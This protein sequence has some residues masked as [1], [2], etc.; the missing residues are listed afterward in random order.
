MGELKSKCHGVR[1]YTF[2][3]WIRCEETKDR[4]DEYVCSE[5]GSSCEI[6]EIEEKEKEQ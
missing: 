3:E 1:A 5:C 4:T 6:E 2:A